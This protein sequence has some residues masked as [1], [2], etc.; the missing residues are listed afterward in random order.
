MFYISVNHNFNLAAVAGSKLVARSRKTNRRPELIVARNSFGEHDQRDVV[1]HRLQVEFRM[2]VIFRHAG[3][4]RP[5]FVEIFVFDGI[6]AN[7]NFVII[8]HVSRSETV[9]RRNR[10]FFVDQRR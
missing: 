3:H 8:R 4:V 2:I 5:F 1:S 9:R 6:I 7:V 10:P